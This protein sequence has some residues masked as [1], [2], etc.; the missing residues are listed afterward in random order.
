MR[1]ACNPDPAANTGGT[2]RPTGDHTCDVEFF[3]EYE[4]RSRMLALLMGAMF[5]VAFRR[6]AA[7]FE[8]R[9]D[10]IYGRANGA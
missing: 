10:A 9:A 1:S 7:A 2:F 3:I 6:F 8:K 5:D 4:F